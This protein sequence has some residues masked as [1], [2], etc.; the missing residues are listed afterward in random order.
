M[1][2]ARSYHTAT[3]L[4]DGRVLV[5]G[6]GHGGDRPFI[7]KTSE[8]YDP[9]TGNWSFTDHMAKA[10]YGHTAT[11]LPDGRVLITGGAGPGGDC[12]NTVTA[13]LYDPVSATWKPTRPMATERGFHTVALLLDGKVLVAG[14]NTID[15]QGLIRSVPP[16]CTAIAQTAEVY[17]PYSDTWTPVDSMAM[18]RSGQTATLLQDG[19]VVIAGGRN[20]DGTIYGSVA[21]VEVYDPDIGTWSSTGNMSVAR[22]YHTATLLNDG[23]VLVCG[24]HSGVSFNQQQLSTAEIFAP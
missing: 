2:I 17:D 16:N 21:S 6:G 5:T 12:V 22:A 8:I 10:R 20:F 7:E 24:G 15:Q 13:E 14:G 9:S 11:L 1:A 19:R 3:L 4:S 18:S 23:R